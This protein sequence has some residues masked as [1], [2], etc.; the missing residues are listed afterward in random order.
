M[1][2]P[3]SIIIRLKGSHREEASKE[4]TSRANKEI[5][6]EI[7]IMWLWQSEQVYST[8]KYGEKRMRIS[9]LI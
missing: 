7:S 5:N 3:E 8:V 2:S 6:G 1:D 9:T 4:E